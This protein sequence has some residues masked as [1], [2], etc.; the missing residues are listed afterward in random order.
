MKEGVLWRRKKGKRSKE[1]RGGEYD[2]EE[3]WDRQEGDEEK[4]L[5]KEDI[6]R[7][8]R[9]GGLWG[10]RETFRRSIIKASWTRALFD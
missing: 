9:G 4:P 8:R 3:I 10:G 7:R 6:E 5:I 1:E 2:Q